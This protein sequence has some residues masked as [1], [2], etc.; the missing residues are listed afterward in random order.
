MWRNQ[1]QQRKEWAGNRL[2]IRAAFEYDWKHKLSLAE[3]FLGK[4]KENGLPGVREINALVEQLK[5]DFNMAA[6]ETRIMFPYA[7][8]ENAMRAS[9]GNFEKA[10]SPLSREVLPDDVPELPEVVGPDHPDYKYDWDY[11][12]STD[13]IHPVDTNYDHPLDEVDPSWM[14]NHLRPKEFEQSGEGVG[15]DVDE[16]DMAW[17]SRLEEPNLS[18]ADWGEDTSAWI[19]E[20]TEVYP[21]NFDTNPATERASQRYLTQAY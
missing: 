17:G 15:F 5:E 1:A 12:A 19:S 3:T 4:L 16:A 2:Q 11:V 9:L 10:P 18:S 14:L 21:L 6:W 7:H 8:K 13:P 20:A